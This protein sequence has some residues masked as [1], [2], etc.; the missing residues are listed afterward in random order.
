MFS[1]AQQ[2]ARALTY[3]LETEIPQRSDRLDP[4]VKSKSAP[5]A[6][7]ARRSDAVESNVQLYFVFTGIFRTPTYDGRN[8]MLYPTPLTRIPRAL[9][10]AHTVLITAS[11]L[12]TQ[13][14][15]YNIT[16]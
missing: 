16:K 12:T 8:I 3:R 7:R 2:H 4:Q 6:T 9:C 1:C 14:T 11:V 10:I 13:H 15:L 5:I